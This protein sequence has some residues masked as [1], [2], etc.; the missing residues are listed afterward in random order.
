MVIIV[1]VVYFLRKLCGLFTTVNY[2]CIRVKNPGEG[3]LIFFPKSV[4]G[5]RLSGRIVRTGHPILGFVAF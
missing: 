2:R 4:G 5:S 1:I 3:Y